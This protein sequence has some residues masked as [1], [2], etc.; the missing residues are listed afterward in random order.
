MQAQKLGIAQPFLDA[1]YVKK[2]HLKKYLPLNILKIEP[3]PMKVNYKN[4]LLS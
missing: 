3:K 4:N 1:K 2:A